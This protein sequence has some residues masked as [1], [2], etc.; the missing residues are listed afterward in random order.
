MQN[1][2][3]FVLTVLFSLFVKLSMLLSQPGLSFKRDFVSQSEYSWS[4]K[5]FRSFY[6]CPS[7]NVLKFE[8]L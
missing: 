6:P 7:K 3:L 1:I 8:Q 5:S 4:K 2:M